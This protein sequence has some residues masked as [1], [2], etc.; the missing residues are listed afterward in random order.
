MLSPS[1][2]IHYRLYLGDPFR[3]INDRG[4][5]SDRGSYF[6]P[7]NSL[8]FKKTAKKSHT[9]SK[10]C[11]LATQKSPTDFH[12]PKKIPLAKLSDIKKKSFG[13]PSPS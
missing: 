1:I 7:K 11:L 10:L 5:G 9:S 8:C 12:R 13:P 3:Y 6:I 4:V 2:S